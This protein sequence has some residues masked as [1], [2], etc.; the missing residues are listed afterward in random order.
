MAEVYR[1]D[2]VGL[3][4]G[5]DHLSGR[6]DVDRSRRAV[7]CWVHLELLHPRPAP[8]D[9]RVVIDGLD[10]SG[11]VRGILVRWLRTADGAWFGVVTYELGYADGRRH[12][13]LLLREQLVPASALSRRDDGKP[14]SGADRW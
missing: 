8:G 4:L 5:D 14:L 13:W 12:G 9:R 7:A 3:H 2:L 1:P 6:A 10:W 11:R